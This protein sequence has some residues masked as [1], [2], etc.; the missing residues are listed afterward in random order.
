MRPIVKL[1]KTDAAGNPTEFNPWTDA[2]PTLVDEIGCFC[3]YCE[4]YNSSSALEVEHICGKGCTDATGSLKYDH[5]KYR[6]NNF[7]LSCKNCNTIKSKKDIALT[8]PF[9]PHQNNLL[10][11]ITIG[12]GG[13][14]QIKGGVSAAD[15]IRVQAFL[16]LVGLDRDPSHPDYSPKDDRWDTRLA[17][18]DL[19]KRQL[20]KY[21]STT[22]S[23][24]IEN[25]VEL[26]KAKG[27]FSVWYYQFWHHDEV[28][29]ALINGITISGKLIKP[30]PG[31]HL[32]SFDSG[33]HFTTLPRP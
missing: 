22:P 29:D 20:Q 30:F 25:I 33:N 16:D 18:Y 19:A 27:F 10:H 7:L 11:F 17:V 28:I 5:L 1:D 26:A 8:N 3:S 15:R 32:S 9:L 14:I 31:T 23:T 6:W 24:D 12:I 21:T 2:K 4:K 13:T